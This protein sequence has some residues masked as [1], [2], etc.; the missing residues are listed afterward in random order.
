MEGSAGERR[1]PPDVSGA[2]SAHGCVPMGVLRG[3]GGGSTR[4]R[5]FQ[6]RSKDDRQC[7]P[8]SAWRPARALG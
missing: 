6:K 5:G 4:R 8:T 7:L 1:H 3:R 2:T